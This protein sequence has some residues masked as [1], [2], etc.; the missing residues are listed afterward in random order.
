MFVLHY[1]TIMWDMFVIVGLICCYTEAIKVPH[2]F[3]FD[4]HQ[5]DEGRIYH[6]VLPLPM[7]MRRKW[8]GDWKGICGCLL[9]TEAEK[10]VDCAMGLLSVAL[11]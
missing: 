10:L 5:P 11:V 9:E 7:Y 1:F 2:M 3:P 6:I 8:L 4:L